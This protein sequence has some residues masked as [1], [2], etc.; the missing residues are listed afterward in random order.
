MSRHISAL[1]RA[2]LVVGSLTLTIVMPGCNDQAEP[3]R[4]ETAADAPK[5]SDAVTHESE[6]SGTATPVPTKPDS[7]IKESSAGVKTPVVLKEIAVD[8]GN[9]VNLVMIQIPA[10]E[11]AM[12]SPDSDVDALRMQKPQHQVR[13]TKP[14][15]LGKYLVTQEQWEAVMGNNPSQL[16]GP[17]NPVEMIS[18]EDCQ[19]FLT[20][21][22]AKNGER[23]GKF[24]LPTEAQ[25]EYACRAGSTTRYCFGDDDSM[26]SQF[27]W[28]GKNSGGRSHPVGTKKPNAWGLYDMHG[29]VWEYCQDWFSG[30]YYAN[31]PTDDPTGPEKG[32]YRVMRGGSFHVTFPAFCRS[33]YRSSHVLNG[34]SYSQGFRLAQIP[35]E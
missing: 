26:L 1:A 4:P 31:S 9:G 27:G 19:G 15:N 28:H 13:I 2:A 10:G 34:K 11:F 5:K 30:S 8:L 17:K 24:V 18:W 7:G 25:W 12:G 6:K 3:A 32:D 21:L 23:G 16:K 35:A 29:N 14:F 20:K 22:K 33:A